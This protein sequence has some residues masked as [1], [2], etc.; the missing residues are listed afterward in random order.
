MKQVHA[1]EEQVTT[2]DE[3]SGLE[4]ENH[5]TGQHRRLPVGLR[6]QGNRGVRVHKLL[7]GN[8]DFLFGDFI[9]SLIVLKQKECKNAE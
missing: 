6:W 9:G 3:T 1:G 4:I 8:L 2:L 7:N 5:V